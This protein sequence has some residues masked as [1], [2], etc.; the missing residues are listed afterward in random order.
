MSEA[1]RCVKCGGEASYETGFSIQGDLN[2]PGY[3]VYCEPCAPNQGRGYTLADLQQMKEESQAARAAYETSLMDRV[4][5]D[6]YFAVKGGHYKPKRCPDCGLTD[7][8]RHFCP[9]RKP[10]VG[11]EAP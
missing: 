6:V 7:V 9:N 4:G 2:A 5:P 11:E 10:T 1:A 3:E 8:G